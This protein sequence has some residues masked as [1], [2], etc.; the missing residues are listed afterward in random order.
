MKLPL[1]ETVIAA[2]M[3]QVAEAGVSMEK[4]IDEQIR[5]GLEAFKEAFREILNTL[6]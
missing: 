3:K 2:H 4:V 1:A 5:E 6:E